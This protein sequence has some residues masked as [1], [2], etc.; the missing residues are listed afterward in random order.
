ML[1]AAASAQKLVQYS[2]SLKGK[3]ELDIVLLLCTKT[4]DVHAEEDSRL[5]A[6]VC[7]IAK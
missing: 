5:K 3:V 6:A 2:H 7:K 4:D 1:A